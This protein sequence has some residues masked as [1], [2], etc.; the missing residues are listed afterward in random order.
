MARTTKANTNTNKAVNSNIAD[1]RIVG[2]LTDV[3]EGNKK[4]YLTI[5]VEGDEINP[6]T[7]EPYYNLL[8][9]TADKDIELYDDGT[10][11]EIGGTISSY[12]DKSVNRSA[13]ILTAGNVK[14]VSNV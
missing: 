4:N 9:V 1:F 3:Y 2:E 10:I 13:M 14:P 12:F 8:K 6:K 5:K 11:V 7:K